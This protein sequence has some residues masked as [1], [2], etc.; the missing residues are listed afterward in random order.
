M[1]RAHDNKTKPFRFTLHID[2][3]AV[4]YF[5]AIL[6]TGIEAVPARGDFKN[7]VVDI[8]PMVNDLPAYKQT[9]ALVRKLPY[10]M[11]LDN[12]KLATR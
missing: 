11:L 4:G 7:D 6:A 10:S 3:F 5:E 1:V 2:E 9:A 8:A 12:L